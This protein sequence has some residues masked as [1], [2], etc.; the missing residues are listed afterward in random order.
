MTLATAGRCRYIKLL[1]GHD[2]VFEDS[3][4]EFVRLVAV[5]PPIS[6][7]SSQ[8]PGR[9]IPPLPTGSSAVLTG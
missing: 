5:I 4:E 9:F 7:L 3:S 6:R 8:A 2:I 1:D